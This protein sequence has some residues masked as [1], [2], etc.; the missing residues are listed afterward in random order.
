MKRAATADNIAKVGKGAMLA[1]F[2]VADRLPFAGAV[3]VA[4]RSMLN[5]YEVRSQRLR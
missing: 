2:A 5:M 1:L 4:L 3:A